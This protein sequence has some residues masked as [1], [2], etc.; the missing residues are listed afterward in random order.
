MPEE[1]NPGQSAVRETIKNCKE[2]ISGQ[3]HIAGYHCGPTTPILFVTL[4]N[5][6]KIESVN[7]IKETIEL[8]WNNIQGNLVILEYPGTVD[9]AKLV[10][11]IDSSIA[12]LKS[13]PDGIFKTYINT[14]IFL[15]VESDDGRFEEYISILNNNLGSKFEQVQLIVVALVNEKTTEKKKETREKLSK[16]S[17][18]KVERKIQGLLVLSNLL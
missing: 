3:R 16:L 12:K 11:E 15:F 6:C 13:A 4:G 5:T 10:S 9:E 18:L 2:S 7:L 17:K 8:A 1:F 14:K